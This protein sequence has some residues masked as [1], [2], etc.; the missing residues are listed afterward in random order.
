[1]DLIDL[2]EELLVVE[3]RWIITPK[4]KRKE[5]LLFKIMTEDVFYFFIRE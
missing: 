4:G 2:V 3:D 1:M 5:D